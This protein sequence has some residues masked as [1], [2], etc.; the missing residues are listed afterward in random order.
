MK[1]LFL[2]LN[3]LDFFIRFIDYLQKLSI[4]PNFLTPL[5]KLI[6]ILNDL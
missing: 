6:R 4:I 1:F 5:N 2:K 3:F